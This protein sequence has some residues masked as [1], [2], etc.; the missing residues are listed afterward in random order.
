MINWGKRTLLLFCLLLG[1]GSALPGQVYDLE[2]VK[3]PA[4]VSFPPA[5]EN[6]EVVF[7][8]LHGQIFPRWSGCD[9]EALGEFSIRYRHSMHPNSL[10]YPEEVIGFINQV[11][12]KHGGNLSVIFSHY[13]SGKV[14]YDSPLRIYNDTIKIFHLTESDCR[15]FYLFW[16][17]SFYRELDCECDYTV[18]GPRLSSEYRDSIYGQRRMDIIRTVFCDSLEA[19]GGDA[20]RIQLDAKH[21][22]GQVLKLETQDCLGL[23]DRK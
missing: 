10:Y 2:V 11:T 23:G 13:Q 16:E 6:Q 14:F 3:E 5:P 17:N 4:I 12:R 19:R 18:L 22:T 20:L 15:P 7:V 1:T 9:A 21:I 8:G